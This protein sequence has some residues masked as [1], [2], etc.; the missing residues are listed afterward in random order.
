MKTK[1]KYLAVLCCFLVSIIQLHSQGYLVPNG[2]MTNLIQGEI[3]VW[4]PTESQ[5]TG[6][7]FTPIGMSQFAIYTNVFN[8]DEPLTIGVRVFLVSSNDAISL[9]PI[10]SHGFTELLFP[11]NYIFQAGV[12]FYVGLYTG[13]SIAPP[14]PFLPPYTYNDPV[15][16]WAELENVNGAIQVLD[17][18]VE[19][20]G[21]GIY[22]GTDNIIPAPE[23]SVFALTALGGLLLGFRRWTK[24]SIFSNG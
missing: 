2:V 19:Y 7:T 9:Q 17:Y 15:F 11:A 23:P 13:E 4:N 5:A 14:G 21:G 12:P 6:F 22:A 3:D 24:P 10:L 8:F 1:F 18:A 20:Q 16:G